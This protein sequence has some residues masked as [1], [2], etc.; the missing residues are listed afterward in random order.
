MAKYLNLRLYVF[1]LL[2]FFPTFLGNLLDLGHKKNV[3]DFFLIMHEQ[4]LFGQ[5]SR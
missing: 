5:A 2:V 1:C 4:K 3:Y